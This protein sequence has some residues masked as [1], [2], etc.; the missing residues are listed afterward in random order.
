MVGTCQLSHCRS[1]WDR[2]NMHGWQLQHTG[3]VSN[4]LASLGREVP[5]F[6]AYKHTLLLIFLYDGY[7]LKWYQSCVCWTAPPLNLMSY[8]NRWSLAQ[9][10]K[11]NLFAVIN[12]LPFYTDNQISHFNSNKGAFCC[13]KTCKLHLQPHTPRPCCG[14]ELNTRICVVPKSGKMKNTK[15]QTPAHTQL[16]H[17]RFGCASQGSLFLWNNRLL[18]NTSLLP[19]N[20]LSL[21]TRPDRDSTLRPKSDQELRSDNKYWV[22]WAGRWNREERNE[23]RKRKSLQMEI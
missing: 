10:M 17:V 1:G 3:P 2:G 20:P 8:K 5:V 4:S 6:R 22:F 21:P 15:F 23:G 16:Q 18:M 11:V 7:T 19:P 13:L 14:N 12:E 9:C